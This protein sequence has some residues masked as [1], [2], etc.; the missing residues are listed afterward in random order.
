MGWFK[1]HL[2]LTL[3]LG[4]IGGGFL[5][6][7]G[8]ILIEWGEWGGVVI[9]FVTCIWVL[10]QKGRSLFHLLWGFLGILFFAVWFLDNKRRVGLI[11]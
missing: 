11:R 5:S 3:F 1:E 2:N 10:K 4:T 6:Y 8:D 9:Y 7:G